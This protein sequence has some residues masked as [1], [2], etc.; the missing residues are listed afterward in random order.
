MRDSSKGSS[1]KS[2]VLTILGCLGSHQGCQYILELKAAIRQVNGVFSLELSCHHMTY[3]FLLVSIILAKNW[4][5][6]MATPSTELPLWDSGN[7]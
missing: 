6:H 7:E 3:I 1:S 4:G 5:C 2:L